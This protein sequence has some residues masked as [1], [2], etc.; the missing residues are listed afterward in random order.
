MRKAT[1]QGTVS[2][3]LAALL[4]LLQGYERYGNLTPPPDCLSTAKPKQP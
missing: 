3:E 2:P 1:I 4:C